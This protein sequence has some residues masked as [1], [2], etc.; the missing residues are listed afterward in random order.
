MHIRLLIIFLLISPVLKP[1]QAGTIKVSINEGWRFSKQGDAPAAVWEATDL[2]HTWN[3]DD[4]MDDEPGYYQGKGWYTRKLV[5]N[6]EQKNLVH[7]LHFEGVGQSAEVFINGKKAGGHA[8]GY[9][10]FT[11]AIGPYLKWENEINE[12]VI[13]VVADNSHDADLPPLSAD[14]TFYGGIYRDV[15]HITAEQVHAEKV[16]H[17]TEA[18]YITQTA[19]NDQRAAVSIAGKVLNKSAVNKTVQLIAAVK[20][21]NGETVSGKELLFLIKRGE[22]ADISAALPVI[23]RPKLWSPEDP[24]LYTVWIT[25]KDKQSGAV[26]EE[27]SIPLGLRWYTFDAAKGFFLNG[28]PYKLIGASRHQDYAGKG[29]AV[30]D[31]L[32]VQDVKLLKEM[33]GNF[34]RVAHYP[35]DPAVLQ[36]CDRLGIIASV[37]IP[38]VNEITESETFYRNCETMLAEMIYQHYN[39]PSVVIWCYMN[40]VLLRM[41]Y[42]NDKARQVRYLSSVTSLARRLDSVARE[43]DPLRYTMIAH[44][45]DFNKYHAAQL[46]EIP[47]LVGWNLYSGWYGGAFKDFAAFLDRHRSALPHKPLLVTEYGADADPRIRSFQPVRFDKSLEYATAYHQYY[48]KA[49]MERPFVAAAMIWNL[50]DFNSETRA[51]TMPHINNK[52]LLTWDRIPKDGYYY[53][54]SQLSSHPFIK[55]ADGGWSYRAGVADSSGYCYQPVQVMTNFDT[56]QI[57][58]NDIFIQKAIA[59][60]GVAECRL[61]FANG[62]N[63]IKAVG[64]KHPLNYEDVLTV[65]FSLSPY[66]FS[67]D[68]YSIEPLNILLGASRYFLDEEKKQVWIPDQPYRPGSFGHVGGKDFRVRQNSRLPYGT[69]KNIRGTF[70]DPVYQTQRTGLEQYRLDV[71]AGKYELTLHFAELEGGT[72]E[73]LVYNLGEG[74]RKEE[75]RQ[76]VFDIIINDVKVIPGLNL[77]KEHGIAKAVNKKVIV[78][79]PGGKGIVIRFQAIAGEPVLNALQV[80]KLN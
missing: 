19:V 4:V 58:V 51:E 70:A 68:V 22:A 74:E 72:V 41:P 75:I 6:Q 78:D 3:T 69:D 39:H 64:F 43:L 33:G 59:K 79:V 35:Q 17:G 32:A 5:L 44:H 28:K 40:E 29:N 80:V 1:Q 27:I 21:R 53:Y 13:T 20:D 73:G 47:M 49:M 25:I 42:N 46:T 63:K 57:F 54:Q 65:D 38:V 52:G 16:E 10:A 2:P 48:L 26:Y 8:G 76:R 24:Y 67:P 50:A 18:I 56:V 60:D 66:R 34:L 15:F 7:Y 62:K 14:F 77:V 9:T 23:S 45:G 37:E 30:P 55:I 12:N 11:I 36:A 31:E 61:P 71:P